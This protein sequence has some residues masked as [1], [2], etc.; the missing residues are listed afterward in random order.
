MKETQH[1]LLQQL[2]PKPRRWQQ[3]NVSRVVLLVFPWMMPAK[4]P[5]KGASTANST[6]MKFKFKK[7]KGGEKEFP[8]NTWKWETRCYSLPPPALLS[9]SRF[10]IHPSL[11][12]AGF[13]HRRGNKERREDAAESPGETKSPAQAQPAAAPAAPRPEPADERLHQPPPSVPS[14]Q[15]EPPVHSLNRDQSQL[16]AHHLIWNGLRCSLL[17]SERLH[18]HT[19]VINKPAL[20][21]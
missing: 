9:Q 4:R 19:D 10:M 12:G 20:V 7:K 6:K 14:P 11:R 1:S 3:G 8:N 13:S 16:C 18:F 2:Q 21:T 17:P 5:A 15:L